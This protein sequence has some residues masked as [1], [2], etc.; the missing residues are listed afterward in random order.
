MAGLNQGR[1]KRGGI[2]CSKLFGAGALLTAQGAQGAGGEAM[3][4]RV[5]RISGQ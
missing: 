3:G 2:D 1:V 5:I 4:F